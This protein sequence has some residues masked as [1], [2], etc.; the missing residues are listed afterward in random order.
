MNQTEI[1]KQLAKPSND[2]HA[3]L[4]RILD[5]LHSSMDRLRHEIREDLSAR[6]NRIGEG[7]AQKIEPLVYAAQESLRT[8]QTVGEGMHKDG[9]MASEVN[10]DVRQTLREVR[11]SSWG[12]TVKNWVAMIGVSLLLGLLS[13][14][15][16]GWQLRS[17]DKEAA[18]KWKTFMEKVYP[19]TSQSFQHLIDEQMK[20]SKKR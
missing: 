12:Q 9:T 7:L 16:S 3:L 17:E 2:T 1:A 13:N 20:S 15:F 14:V 19:Q 6:E 11:E 4:T 18:Q 5:V 8:F 10:R